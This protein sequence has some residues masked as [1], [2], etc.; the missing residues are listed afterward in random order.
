[1]TRG[2]AGCLTA[3]V[4]RHGGRRG[5]FKKNAERAQKEHIHYNAGAISIRDSAVPEHETGVSV[6]SASEPSSPSLRLSPR[7]R[8]SVVNP[9]A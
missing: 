2:V 6:I 9:N 8:V 4:Q 5:D 7:R 1:M 3:K